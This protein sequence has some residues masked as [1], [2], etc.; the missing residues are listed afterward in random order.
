MR[1][2]ERNSAGI[3]LGDVIAASCE[4]GSAVSPDRG[5]AAELAARH[6]GRMLA[7]G[8]NSR[9]AAAMTL[10]ARELDSGMA[11]AVGSSAP[12]RFPASQLA[13]ASR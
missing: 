12:A 2:T 6:V 7:R 3:S 1:T 8:G 10:L 9:L 5:V 13:V 11:H 4:L